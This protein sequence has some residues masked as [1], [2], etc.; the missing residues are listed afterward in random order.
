LKAKWQQLRAGGPVDHLLRTFHGIKTWGVGA[1]LRVLASKDQVSAE[2][3]RLWELWHERQPLPET[4]PHVVYYQS[5]AASGC[6]S[7][8]WFGLGLEGLLT[9]A[10]S[11]FLLAVPKTLALLIGLLVCVL[12][13][14]FLKGAVKMFL[15][16]AEHHPKKVLRF[17]A[18]TIAVLLAIVLI[19]LLIGFLIRGAT[20]FLALLMGPLFSIVLSILSVLIP[21]VSGLLFLASA[22]LGW[23][24]RLNHQYEDLCTLERKILELDAHV[25]YRIRELLPAPSGSKEL[26]KVPVFPAG[27]TLVLMVLLCGGLSVL[28]AQ[29]VARARVDITSSVDRSDLSNALLQL[30]QLSAPLTITFGITRW[31]FI[32]FSDDGWKAVPTAAVDM[33]ALSKIFCEGPPPSEADFFTGVAKARQEEAE[34]KCSQMKSAA[35]QQYEKSLPTKLEEWRKNLVLPPVVSNRCT[36]FFDTLTRVT[37]S[38]EPALELIFSDGVETCRAPQSIPP[39]SSSVKVVLVVLNTLSHPQRSQAQSF[40]ERKQELQRFAPWLQVIPAWNLTVAAISGREPQ[41][42]TVRLIGNK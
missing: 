24:V 26:V 40:F 31:E 10:M 22:L 16:A 7:G 5:L 11:I 17:I 13:A 35:Q 37:M 42:T 23:S 8:A 9:T 33:P 18:V 36:S 28:R 21:V 19:V 6:A 15:P 3:R 4:L 2:F 32:P 1:K 41:A 38:Q 39:P 20:G 25:D 12:L 27:A 30:S 29:P 14:F 34:K